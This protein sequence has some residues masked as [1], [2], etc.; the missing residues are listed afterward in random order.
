MDEMIIRLALRLKF[1][2]PFSLME[3]RHSASLM[4]TQNHVE[5]LIES[6]QI[7]ASHL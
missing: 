7:H 4:I 6:V 3:I 5:G 2:I 1:Q